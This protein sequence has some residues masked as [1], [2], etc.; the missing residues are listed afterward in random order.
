MKGPAWTV[1]ALR[2]VWEHQQDRVR[3]RIGVIERA[4]AALTNDRL[5]SYL[6]RDAERAAHMLASSV[7]TFGF[8]GA[9]EA[10]RALELELA[11]HPKPDRA[12]VLSALLLRVHNGVRGPVV[13]CSRTAT[14]AD[15]GEDPR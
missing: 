6:R 11:R 14:E 4:I 10:A 9:S 7:G 1:D 5:D 13:L 3:E 8:I 12:P 15:I 2:S